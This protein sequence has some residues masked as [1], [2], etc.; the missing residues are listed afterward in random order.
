[1]ISIQRFVRNTKHKDYYKWHE[2][3]SFDSRLSIL[4]LT[5]EIRKTKNTPNVIS[6]HSWMTTGQN[7]LESS[8]CIFVWFLNLHLQH[9]N[10]SF[11]NKSKNKTKIHWILSKLKEEQPQDQQ[12]QQQQQQKLKSICPGFGGGF[13]ITSR[14]CSHHSLTQSFCHLVR[15]WVSQFGRR[16]A[17]YRA[18]NST[19]GTVRTLSLPSTFKWM[20]CKPFIG[21]HWLI[22][23]SIQRFLS[24]DSEC[25][26]ATS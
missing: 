19:G 24:V 17:L 7:V 13:S 4:I 1:M 10:F 5:E 22:Y 12:Q 6:Q 3:D 14:G 26:L 8:K 15:Q 2:R 18:T 11:F 9:G 23:S 20:K 25:V 21:S 16:H